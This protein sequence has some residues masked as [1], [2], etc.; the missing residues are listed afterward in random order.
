MKQKVQSI[1]TLTELFPTLAGKD[2]KKSLVK[3]RKRFGL[4]Q[5]NLWCQPCQWKKSCIRQNWV[6]STYQLLQKMES[7]VIIPEMPSTNKQ[8]NHVIIS[9]PSILSNYVPKSNTKVENV[10]P[11]SGASSNIKHDP[12][13]ND[14]ST[15]SSINFLRSASE[16]VSTLDHESSSL[17]KHAIE[18]ADL[19]PLMNCLETRGDARIL[20][21]NLS[22]ESNEASEITLSL[23]SHE[24]TYTGNQLTIVPDLSR[25]SSASSQSILGEEDLISST[26]ISIDDFS[27]PV[28]TE[29]L[30]LG[31]GLEPSEIILFDDETMTTTK[32]KYVYEV[33]QTQV[34]SEPPT[35]IQTDLSIKR[36]PDFSVKSEPNLDI[37][38]EPEFTIKSEP[39]TY[40]E[41]DEECE[42]GNILED[43]EMEDF[44]AMLAETECSSSSVIANSEQKET[45]SGS[46]PLPTLTPCPP[47]QSS[48][49]SVFSCDCGYCTTNEEKFE[50]HIRQCENDDLFH[51][52][53]RG[54]FFSQ[55]GR[56]KVW[57]CQTCG[58]N[59]SDTK[60]FQLHALK[61]CITIEPLTAEK[62]EC[63]IM[64]DG[65]VLDA[66]ATLTDAKPAFI[67]YCAYCYYKTI[68]SGDMKIHESTHRAYKCCSCN[69]V[70]LSMSYLPP[71]SKRCN[72]SKPLPNSSPPGLEM[73][74]K[75]PQL[76]FMTKS[77]KC[78][79]M[80]GISQRSLWCQPCQWKKACMRQNWVPS[81]YPLSIFEKY[82]KKFRGYF[83]AYISD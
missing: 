17:P 25:I 46:Y 68:S 63:K 79:K 67:Y 61:C 37:K 36:E 52:L 77:F 42:P 57:T 72:P 11:T 83:G 38:T 16:H 20:S 8:S 44:E 70:A 27:Q 15:V 22:P 23:S 10:K 31:S 3:C 9:G 35:S 80:F 34:P 45:T 39:C 49:S 71:H 26:L 19:K 48:E 1:K 33:D 69:Y 41:E 28:K 60:H 55:F 82:Y 50:A 54:N 18:S 32:V 14:I 62:K 76:S 81:T 73:M 65:A 78:R 24:K 58:Y 30:E 4:S 13:S 5:R 6:P 47:Q 21:E 75:I 66:S 43:E 56:P 64:T 59:T 51:F 74:K 40:I 29:S 12:I 53:S 2:E 7:F